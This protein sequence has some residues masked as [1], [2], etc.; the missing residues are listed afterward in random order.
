MATFGNGSVVS[1]DSEIHEWCRA[2]FCKHKGI[3]KY[4]VNLLTVEIFKRGAIPYYG[5][6]CSNIASRNI[7]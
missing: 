4:L 2:F 3:A 6:W 5:T 7:A 1:A